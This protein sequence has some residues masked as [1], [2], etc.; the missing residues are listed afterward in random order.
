MVPAAEPRLP[1]DTRPAQVAP[2]PGT[3]LAR[4]TLTK[5]AAQRLGITTVPVVAEPALV[6]PYAAVIY[7]TN[8]STW[9]Y[10]NPAP[11]AYVRHRISINRITGEQAVLSDG[12]AVGTPVVTTGAAELFGAERGVG[13]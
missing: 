6:V 13:K 1:S 10:T 3:D 7:D 2:I 5:Q 9:V 12:P 4:V 11:L 8:G